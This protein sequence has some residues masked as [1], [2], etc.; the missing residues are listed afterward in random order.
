MVGQ[1]GVNKRH[2]RAICRM[3]FRLKVHPYT[4]REGQV[5]QQA[6]LVLEIEPYTL[7]TVEAGDLSALDI[8]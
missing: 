6:P 2:P 7:F 1:G 8:I 5:S 3:D 4:S